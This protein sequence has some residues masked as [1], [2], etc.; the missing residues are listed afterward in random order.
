M[1]SGSGGSSWL[2]LWGKEDL[3]I[4]SEDVSPCKAR[5]LAGDLLGILNSQNDGVS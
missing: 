4:G 1:G 3:L 5:K 2:R